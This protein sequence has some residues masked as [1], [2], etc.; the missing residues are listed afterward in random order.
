M[1]SVPRLFNLTNKD[2][3]TG[4]LPVNFKQILNHCN[5]FMARRGITIVLLN[6]GNPAEDK[7]HPVPWITEHADEWRAFSVNPTYETAVRFLEAAPNMLPFFEESF[8][9]SLYPAISTAST[10]SVG[11]CSLLNR[12]SDIRILRELSQQEY[13]LFPKEFKDEVVYNALPVHF[14]GR[15]WKVMVSSVCGRIYKWLARNKVGIDED[16]DVI[17]GKVTRFCIGCLGAT[18]EEL[19]GF[20][21]WDT[22]DGSVILQLTRTD[23]FFEMVIVAISSEIHRLKKG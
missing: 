3:H 21:F 19:K 12:I 5:F 17:V 9:K 6:D 4:V 2:Y 16:L 1:D 10:F 8:Q 11:R 20:L 13:V 18:T 14:A 7:S 23:D 15:K 22:E